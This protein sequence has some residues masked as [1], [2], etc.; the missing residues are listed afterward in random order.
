MPSWAAGAAGT[1]AISAISAYTFLRLRCRG[2]GY[3]LGPHARW[4]AATVVLITALIATGLGAAAVAVSDHL[5]AAYIGII[6]PSG[7]WLGKAAAQ[8][9]HQ[10]A[11]PQLS[12]L[13]DQVTLPLRCLDNS[14]GDDVQ[15]WCDVRSAVVSTTPEL[16]YDAAEHYYL[17]V[18]NQVKDRQRREDLDRPLSSIRHKTSAMRLARLDTTRSAMLR[19]ALQDHPYTRGNGKYAVDSPGRLADRLESEAQ[20]ELHLLLASIY[21]LGYRKLVMYRGLKPTPRVKRPVQPGL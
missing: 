9:G 1:F 5:R 8:H 4:W 15:S 16:I 6:V 19:D 21:R 14:M 7:L 10:R 2:I 11:T 18:A 13:L 12:W 3:P 17:Q 20:N